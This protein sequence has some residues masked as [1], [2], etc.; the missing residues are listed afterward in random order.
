MYFVGHMFVTF[1]V[2]F[3]LCCGFEMPVNSLENLMFKRRSPEYRPLRNLGNRINT[4][5]AALLGIK[6]A[7]AAPDGQK[8]RPKEYT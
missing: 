7:P 3:V 5:S 4:A 1:I 8:D 2:A 6:Q